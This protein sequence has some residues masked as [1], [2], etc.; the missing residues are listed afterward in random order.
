MDQLRARC[1]SQVLFLLLS[2]TC[3]V[4]R[5]IMHMHALLVQ[6]YYFMTVKL[7]YTLHFSS[8]QLNKL[9]QMMWFYNVGR[10]KTFAQYLT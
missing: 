1:I 10:L 4:L 7:C 3:P 5:H 6:K 2:S 9:E 8:I